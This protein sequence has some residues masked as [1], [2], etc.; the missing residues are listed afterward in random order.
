VLVCSS[1]LLPP[2]QIV[3]V[4]GAYLVIAGV[5]GGNNWYQELRVRGLMPGE[6]RRLP[7]R[8]RPRRGS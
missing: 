5:C 8:R 7:G 3:G 1:F 6:D 2:S 4:L